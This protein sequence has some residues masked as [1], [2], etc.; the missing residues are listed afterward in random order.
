MSDEFLQPTEHDGQILIA[1]VDETYAVSE[2]DAWARDREAYRK[3]L[4]AEF[5]LPFCDADI[6]PGASLP[7]F[8]ALL[9]G[10]AIV[11]AWVLLSAA[12][13]LGKPLQENLKAWRDMAAKIRSFFKRPV[14]LNRQGAAVL[15]V[16][17]VF[18][19]MGGLP[20]TIQLIGYRTMHIAEEDL[21]TPPEES[22][23]EALPTLYLGFIRHIFEIKA[24]GVRF[25]VSVD[26][27]KVAIL[28]L[29]EF[30]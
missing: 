27:R 3:S 24:D 23:G 8:V 29:E 6:G 16:E 14:F 21:A 18:N 25:R 1:V 9:Q 19:E 15:A 20:H 26:G 4:E 22:I 2:D 13:F 7:A 5:D 28:R 11:P 17:A 10:T 12:L 30:Q